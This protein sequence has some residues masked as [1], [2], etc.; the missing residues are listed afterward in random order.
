M[1][2]VPKVTL[3]RIAMLTG[4]ISSRVK[5]LKYLALSL[6]GKIG[7]IIYLCYKYIDDEGR[8]V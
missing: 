6:S 4:R 5:R 8:V 2:S 7:R 1:A 3:G